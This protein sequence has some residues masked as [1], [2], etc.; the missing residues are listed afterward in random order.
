MDLFIVPEEQH[1]TLV[2]RAYQ[3]RGYTGEE[4][5]SATRM[6]AEATRHG[7]NTHNAIKGLHLDHVLGSGIG[8]WVPGAEIEVVPNRFKAVEAWNAN[9][10]LGQAVAYRAFD[11]CVELAEEYGVGAVSVDNGSHYLWGA[12]YA[13]EYAKRGYIV[14]TNCTSS[15]AEVAPFLGKFPTLGT[16]P[17]TWGFPT[18]HDDGFPVILD[19]ATSE[20][21]MGRVQQLKREGKKLDSSDWAIDRD[22]KP[23]D[24]PHE[25]VA[26][27]TFGRHKGYG[28]AV[29]NE[30]F[31]AVAG[32]SLPTLRGSASPPA[33]EKTTTSF[34]FQVIHPEALTSGDFA[35]G[36]DLAGNVKA[37]INDIL[38]HG[39]EGA[40]LPGGLEHRG[41][42]R[43]QRAGGLLFTAGELR[44]FKN[45]AEECGQPT[46]D[47]DVGNFSRFED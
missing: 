43:T 18:F 15:L 41:F 16:N 29:L 37:V 42:Q 13:I 20:V 36:R 4:A 22:G 1:N 40:I 45:I 7:N 24:D 9:R 35:A 12:G 39:N 5:S 32:G 17:H 10:K 34:Y 30:L 33:E 28:L 3:H 46:A 2:T 14:Y 31:A 47:W 44:E 21:A 6:C 38:G 27:R 23:T 8:N 19:W 11:R 25:V 26:L